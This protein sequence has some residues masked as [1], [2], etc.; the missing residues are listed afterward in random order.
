MTQ[1][2]GVDFSKNTLFCEAHGY[3]L[4]ESFT[5]LLVST[6]LMK[7]FCSFHHAAQPLN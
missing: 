1:N 4:T 3:G 7:T 6:F 5:E 2:Q